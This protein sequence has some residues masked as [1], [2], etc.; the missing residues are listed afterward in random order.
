[1][2]ISK[3]VTHHIRMGQYE[4]VVVGT[5]VEVEVPAQADINEHL[6]DMDAVIATALE[7][8]IKAARELAVGDSYIH[9]WKGTK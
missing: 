1:M 3:S 4:S 8:D 6:D 2:K 9:D 7:P 5:S